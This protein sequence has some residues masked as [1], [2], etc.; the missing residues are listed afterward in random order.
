[1]KRENLKKN[2]KNKQKISGAWYDGRAD[3]GNV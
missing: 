2:R 3:K 1:M